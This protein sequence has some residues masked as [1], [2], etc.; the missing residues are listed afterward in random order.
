M[1]EATISSTRPG[2]ANRRSRHWLVLFL[3]STVGKKV[4]MALTGAIGIGFILLHVSLNLLVYAGPATINGADRFLK[5]TGGWLWLAR[6]ILLGAVVLHIG[7]AYQ[8]SRMSLSSRPVKY[9]QWEPVGSNYASRTMRWSGVLLALFI[10][11]HVLHLATGTLHPH[12]AP[13]NV[14]RNVV[15]AFRVWYVSALYIFAMGLLALHVYHGAWSMFQSLGFNHPRYAGW[16][17][18]VATTLTIV[19]VLGF[20]SIPVAVLLGAIS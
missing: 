17:R 2:P 6:A 20:I 3:G 16:I 1:S 9:A 18:P 4:V 7:T 13:D 15:S 19:V 5:S 8:L 14:Y 11:L 10:P 12:F